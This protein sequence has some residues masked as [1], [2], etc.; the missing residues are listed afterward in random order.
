M[1]MSFAPSLP[2]PPTSSGVVQNKHCYAQ[3]I[4]Q[5]GNIELAVFSFYPDTIATKAQ[6]LSLNVTADG[7]R[8]QTCIGAATSVATATPENVHTC[9]QR[10]ESFIPRKRFLAVE[11][12][13]ACAGPSHLHG[14]GHNS[15]GSIPPVLCGCGI[16]V[17]YMFLP[18]QKR[19]QL[20]S[21]ST[22]RPAV[23]KAGPEAALS[24]GR[25]DSLPLLL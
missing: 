18:S 10:E 16:A 23:V 15:N 9:S 20:F 13:W 2:K 3:H 6:S 25:R 24:L 17:Y 8:T 4:A 1:P 14:P 12:K 11:L 7:S 19:C 21:A 5:C 22:E